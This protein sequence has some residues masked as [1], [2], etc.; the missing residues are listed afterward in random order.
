MQSGVEPMQPQPQPPEPSPSTPQV[1]DANTRKARMGLTPDMEK[2]LLDCVKLHE[3][4]WAEE[5]RARIKRALRA[6]EYDNG[7]QYLSW[8]PSSDTYVNPLSDFLSGSPFNSAASPDGK[9]TLY[10]STNNLVQW[11]RKVFVSTLSS[12]VPRV[13]WWP[14]D[15][16][17]DLD[18]RAAKARS[19]AYRKIGRDNK[20]EDLQELALEHLFLVG[21]YF[22]FVRWSMD[23]KLTGTRMEPVVEWGQQQMVPDRYICPQCGAETPADPATGMAPPCQC[24]YQL[25]SANFHQG[26]TVD[27]PM[28]TG[29]REVPCGEVHFDIFNLLNVNC[30]PNVDTNTGNPIAKTPLLDLQVDI[31]HGAFRT[32]YPESWD[33]VGQSASSGAST[34]ADSASARDARSIGKSIIHFRNVRHPL[35]ARTTFFRCAGQRNACK[36][37]LPVL[38]GID[39]RLF[40]LSATASNLEEI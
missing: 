1:E 34:E 3:E 5:R 2:D 29:Q 27:A 40:D 30:M 12:A 22:R 11:A 16:D 21:S 25:G 4:M 9:S 10:N 6:I 23:E 35:G 14:G 7:N 36:S 17:S 20:E 28:I 19:Q 39:K 8:D 24:G 13:E 26:V 31:T 38:E 18:N 33:E 37:C 32:L 15:A